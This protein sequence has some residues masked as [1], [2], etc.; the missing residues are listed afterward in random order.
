[1]RKYLTFGQACLPF[2]SHHPEIAK[3]QRHSPQGPLFRF[4]AKRGISAERIELRGPSFL[5]DVLKEYADIDI[6]PDPFP[7]PGSLTVCEPHG[8]AW[9][10]PLS[11]SRR[12]ELSAVRDNTPSFIRSECL[13][14]VTHKGRVREDSHSLR[15]EYRASD[16]IS[17]HYSFS[18]EWIS[19]DGSKASRSRHGKYIHFLL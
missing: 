7:F 10:D 14:L 15:N 5:V 13:D 18:H 8:W 2:C 9:G 3:V 6:A 4:F 11:H 12:G 19:S 17:S 1:M 16:R